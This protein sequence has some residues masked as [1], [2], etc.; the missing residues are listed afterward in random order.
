VPVDRGGL[1]PRVAAPQRRLG[2]ARGR[3][4][5]PSSGSARHALAHRA[6]DQSRE[7]GAAGDPLR[8]GRPDRLSRRRVRMRQPAARVARRGA[9]RRRR[10]PAAARRGAR[11]RPTR[12]P[13]RTSTRSTSRTA[14][15]SAATRPASRSRPAAPIT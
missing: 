4:R 6:P 3:R 12:T 13:R 8:R 10:D 9:L 7:P 14:R 2:G 1:R 11:S 15:P 5:A